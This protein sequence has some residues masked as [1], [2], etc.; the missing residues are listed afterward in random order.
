MIVP[1]KKISLIVLDSRRVAS[2][3]RLQEAGLLHVEVEPEPT[4][5]LQQLIQERQ[6][7]DRAISTL[8]TYQIESEGE[9]PKP[10]KTP[11]EP[12]VD[13]ALELA[14]QIGQSLDRLR[15]LSETRDRLQREVS[16][17]EPW[18]AFD[19]EDIRGLREKGYDLRLGTLPPSDF[20]K[21]E[22]PHSVILQRSKSVVRFLALAFEGEE[23]PEM[24]Y[25]PLPEKGLE[26]LRSEIDEIGRQQES[27]HRSIR[28]LITKKGLL[29]SARTEVN[30]ALQFERVRSGME[31]EEGISWLTGFAP[32]K[33]VDD[34]RRLAEEE[35]WGIL[36]RDP[37]PGDIVPTKVE[38]PKSVRMVKPVFDMLGTVPGYQEIDISFWFLAFFAVFFAMII[39]DGGYG[40][41]LLG[42]TVASILSSKRQGKPLALGQI[43]LAVLSASTVVWG[44]ITGNWFGVTNWDQVGS[45]IGS[46]LNA[47][48]V[49]PIA[50]RNEAST[51]TVQ[52]LTFIIGTVQLGLAHTWNVLRE[53]KSKPRITAFAEVGWFAVVVGLYFLVLNIVLGV[54]GIPTFALYL[55]GGGLGAVFLFSYQEEGQNFFLGVLKALG[56]F[57]TVFLDG[58]SAF[59]D[60]ISYIR[61]YAVGLASLRIAESFNSMATGVGEGVGGIGGIAA[62]AV[63]LFL[64]HSLNLAMAALSVVVHGVRL[65]MLEFS[66]HLGMEW[67]GVPYTPFQKHK[68]A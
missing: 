63:I 47:I 36:V 48:I 44:A 24:E 56:N 32:A 12:D 42:G 5:S 39:G 2:L 62:M 55:M 25:T 26:Q 28:E 66:G 1:M 35:G 59:S 58:V 15:E 11:V 27:E 50:A 46:L 9:A 16:R 43:L 45:P 61:L 60:I 53:W 54:E 34:F 22:F 40:L 23:L 57:I 6:S 19:P 38:N 41:V 29:E 18:G 49:E 8:E 20:E 65:N 13:K 3:E 7:L 64:G 67:T 30:D 37:E 52:W 10:E 14:W 31:A 4:D 17:L 51:F 68:T 33:S 21:M